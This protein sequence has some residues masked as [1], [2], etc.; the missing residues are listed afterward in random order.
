[1][2]G[3]YDVPF[4]HQ[5]TARTPIVFPWRN[6][7]YWGLGLPLGLTATVGWAAAGWDLIHRRRVAHLVPWM[8]AT[9]YF[10][11]QGTQWVKSMRYLLPIYPVLTLLAA[12]WIVRIARRACRSRGKLSYLGSIGRFMARSIPYVVGVMTAAWC[13]AFTAI[14]R[15]PVTRVQ[16]SRWMYE[17]I[18]TAIRLRTMDGIL[19][20]VPL[21]AGPVLS[22]AQGG[23]FAHRDQSYQTARAY[24]HRDRGT[25]AGWPW[26]GGSRFSPLSCSGA[27]L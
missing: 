18:P 21:P 16:A 24:H 3:Q 13:F 14:Y 25:Q 5:W 15:Q 23:G 2:S 27:V 9:A 10:L 26:P 19:E 17:N 20:N 22:T 4:G 12:W 1:M 6:L 11:Y 7:V 8:W